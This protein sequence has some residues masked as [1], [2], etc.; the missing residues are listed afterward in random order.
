[1]TLPACAQ[2]PGMPMVGLGVWK[3]PSDVTA[4][5]VYDAVKLGYRHLDCA[6]DYGNEPA[7][8][9]ALKRLFD[10]GVCTREELWITSKLWNTY[11]AREHVLP[12]CQ[13]TLDDLGLD[14]LDLYLIHFPIALKFVPFEERYPPEWTDNGNSGVMR[15]ADV[16][17]RETWEAMEE[18]HAA[19]KA[20]HIGVSNLNVQSLV[21]LLRYAKVRPAC[22]QI[23]NHLYLQQGKLA[24]FCHDHAMAVVGFSPL[25][26]AS[27]VGMGLASADEDAL[28]DPT[29][30][31]IA[32]AKGKTTAQVLLRLQL[33]RGIAV[34]PKSQSAARLRENLDLGGFE[35]DGGEVKQLLALDRNRRFNDPAVYA[36]GWGEPGSWL[37]QHGYPLYE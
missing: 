25:G 5:V 6:C 26:A 17:Y 32:A 10:E 28:K 36:K 30:V 14:Y 11:H 29:V 12:A 15:F 7:V 35:L 18:L 2:L 23:E 21:D 9:A 16:P 34:V 4:Q 3:A 31:R 22:N 33:Q 24:T 1:M 20:K 27:Y 19:G 13:R 8:G 37:A